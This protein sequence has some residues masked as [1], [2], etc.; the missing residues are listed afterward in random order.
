[1][2]PTA[3]LSVEELK[4]T[5]HGRF[6]WLGAGVVLPAIGVLAALGTQDRAGSTCRRNARCGAPEARVRSAF[7]DSHAAAHS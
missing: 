2:S 6:A 7:V 1:M 4:A 5:M 3:M